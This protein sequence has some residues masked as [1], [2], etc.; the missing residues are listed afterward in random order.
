MSA[1]RHDADASSEPGCSR[2]P[3]QPCPD[4]DGPD[5]S[6]DALTGRCKVFAAPRATLYVFRFCVRPSLFLL[7]L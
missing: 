1:G 5:G 7:P 2:D 3:K 4:D 6:D